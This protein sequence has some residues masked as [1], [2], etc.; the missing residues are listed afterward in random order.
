MSF[1]IFITALE[2]REAS[3][4]VWIECVPTTCACDLAPCFP[5]KQ[6]HDLITTCKQPEH[7]S[8]MPHWNQYSPR[9][10]SLPLNVP[11]LDRNIAPKGLGVIRSII[12]VRYA[13][14]HLPDHVK[15][16]QSS[17]DDRQ[18]RRLHPIEMTMMT[19]GSKDDIML[20]VTST[21]RNSDAVEYS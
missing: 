14:I 18:D 17:V 16:D 13:P 1:S 11:S 15:G 12:C 7:H 20:E 21:T 4:Y 2:A 5:I 9:V 6:R 3:D 8:S 10:P 19:P